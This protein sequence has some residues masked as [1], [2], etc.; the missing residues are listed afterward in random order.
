V[1]GWGIPWVGRDWKTPQ[2]IQDGCSLTSIWIQ[3]NS[4][5]WGE[6]T[7][8]VDICLFVAG[9]HY[10]RYD[11]NWSPSVNAERYPKLLLKWDGI[12][13][14]LDDVLCIGNSVYFFR[15]GR[16]YR[17]NCITGLV[18]RFHWLQL[19]KE[20]TPFWNFITITFSNLNSLS[21]KYLTLEQLKTFLST[22][23]VVSQL[24]PHI[25]FKI[26]L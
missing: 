9:D 25:I 24:S 20:V 26:F 11:S 2:T 4:L 7:H 5:P 22:G 16:Y 18:R 23:P 6:T 1:N 8:W 21:F 15:K 19:Y 3:I 12:V 10:W 17:F 13:W 14:V